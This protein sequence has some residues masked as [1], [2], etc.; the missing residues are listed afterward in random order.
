M[1]LLIK[2]R[3]S[4][5]I[6]P[7]ELCSGNWYEVSEFLPYHILSDWGK[8]YTLLHTFCVTLLKWWNFAKT[9]QF[10]HK[11]WELLCYEWI[12]IR[13]W[14]LFEILGCW[15]NYRQK[16]QKFWW[17][18]L[19]SCWLIY[20]K[21]LTYP[22]QLFANHYWYIS[23]FVRYNVDFHHSLI[24]WLLF[25]I[26]IFDF[27]QRRKI[28]LIESALTAGIAGMLFLFQL[29]KIRSSCTVSVGWLDLETVLW[30]YCVIIHGTEIR[31]AFS[32]FGSVI[33]TVRKR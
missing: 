6:C 30:L 7:L 16:H 28:D 3:N 14:T 25:S 24:R 5:A 12:N 21:A 18:Q 20:N 23:H 32:C 10:P 8:S 9:N 2:L 11:R 27:D 19:K 33:L 15:G 22:L 31:D 13:Y 29:L 1:P 26:D 17:T 4:C